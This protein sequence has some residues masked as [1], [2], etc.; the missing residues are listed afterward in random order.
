MTPKPVRLLTS[1]PSLPDVLER[2]RELA[3]NIRWAWDEDTIALF[4]RLDE[5]RWNASGH[6]PVQMLAQVPVT[7]LQ[8]LSED[9]GFVA[10]MNE[11][12]ASFDNYMGAA[13]TW[14]SRTHQH[15]GLLAAYF[16]AE[17]GVTEWISAELRHPDICRAPAP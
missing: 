14:F 16:S 6:N 2:L 7:R 3:Y 17:F 11:V 1:S 12:C 15:D 8:E 9:E 10:H 4:Q 5:D 13:S